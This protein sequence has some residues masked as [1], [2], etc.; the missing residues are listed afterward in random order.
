MKSKWLCYLVDPETKQ[1]LQLNA[2]KTEKSD[3][4]SGEL[5]AE[6]RSYSIV[7]GIPR[8]LPSAASAAPASPNADIEQTTDYFG[9]LFTEQAGHVHS[10]AEIDFHQTV[11]QAMLGTAS[12]ANLKGLFKDGFNCLDAGCGFAW[13]EYLFNDNHN[14]NRFAVDLSRS[15]EVAY[16]RTKELDNV[17]VAQADL[18]RLPFRD[19]F[20]DIIFSCGVIHHTESARDTF[21]CLCKH[22]K[23]G[24]IIGIFVYKKKPF[25]RAQADHSI[26]A[27]TTEMT[28]AETKEFAEQMAKLGRSLQRIS[29]PLVVESD[30]PLLNIKKGEYNLQ[31]F[32]SDH[33]I[34]CWHSAGLG[35][36]LSVSRNADW[37]GPKIASSHTKEEIDSWF[38]E[39]GIG[40][41][42]YEDLEGWEHSGLFA[43]GRKMATG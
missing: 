29:E 27:R 3:V 8:L 32:V 12:M 19:N 34:K 28:F 30:I 38:S 6:D 39:N 21:R 2:E 1:S 26:R 41:A 23:P 42:H 36:E 20:F 25:L 11:L 14:A 37:Y 13:A 17:F 5:R 4:I 33:F 43:S 15:V 18:T 9:D 22:L 16:Q 7:G 31:K 40:K 10:Q 24:G 35:W